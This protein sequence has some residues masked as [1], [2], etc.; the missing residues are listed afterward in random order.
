LGEN[1]HLARKKKRT[2]HPMAGKKNQRFKGKKQEKRGARDLHYWR[3]REEERRSWRTKKKKGLCLRHDKGEKKTHVPS[4]EGKKNRKKGKK[5]PAVGGFPD[6]VKKRQVDQGDDRRRKK[7][8]G[9]LL[10]KKKKKRGGVKRDEYEKG[11][12]QREGGR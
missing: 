7:K 5:M 2:D 10:P 8:G 3:R 11:G 9:I 4:N 6:G 1:P 12:A